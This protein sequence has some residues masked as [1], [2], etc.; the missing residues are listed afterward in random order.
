MQIVLHGAYNCAA[1]ANCAVKAAATGLY[2]RSTRKHVDACTGC[3]GSVYKIGDEDC[4]H[5]THKHA[6]HV[7]VLVGCD[8][9]DNLPRIIVQARTV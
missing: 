4:F 1:E 5:I 7:Q 8:A 2:K 6:P 9:L 3:H